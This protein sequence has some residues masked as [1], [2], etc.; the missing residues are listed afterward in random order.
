MSE[1]AHIAA[2]CRRRK[3]TQL[4]RC[5]SDGKSG[6]FENI[7]RKIEKP[8]VIAATGALSPRIINI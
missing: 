7:L 3:R 5:N 4:L 8:L 2:P 1:A 6:D